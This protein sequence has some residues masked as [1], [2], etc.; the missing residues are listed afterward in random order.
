MHTTAVSLL[1]RLRRP[2]EPA[3]WARFVELYTPLLYHWAR[4]R[5]LQTADAA[6]L[7]QEVFAILVKELPGFRYDQHKSFRNWLRTI[8]FNK[9]R[10]L[11]RRQAARPHTGGDAGLA[12]LAEA[13]CS[14][15]FEEAE[16]RQRLTAR[17]LALMQTEFETATWKA[18]WECVANDRPA[19]EVAQE[20]GIS[21]NAV[22]IA[23][24]R[25]LA[26]LRQELE[27][28]MD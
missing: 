4:Q 21:K 28:L 8:A 25:V 12:D 15:T 22:Y 27:G 23:K 19:A 7:V 17:A 13:S 26:R 16:Y 20:L 5:Q 18:F 10:E 11:R 6:D 3:A 24:S 1:Q 9:W 14:D 2:D